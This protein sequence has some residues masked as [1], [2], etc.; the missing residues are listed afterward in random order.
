MQ[1]LALPQCYNDPYA[2]ADYKERPL[3]QKKDDMEEVFI[4]G[5][6]R[7]PLGKLS[8][9]L[10]AIP[11]LALGAAAIRRTLERAGVE[12]NQVDYTPMGNVLQAG[13]DQVPARQAAIGAGTPVTAS[14]MTVNK[15]RASGLTASVLGAGMIRLGDAEVVVAGD[16]ESMVPHL[17]K[18]SRN[19]VRLSSWEMADSMVQG[20]L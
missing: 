2:T 18:G 20:G 11:A 9:A 6:A 17:L 12:P 15:V 7:T 4:V 8:G 10:S 19:G 14:A 1:G 13:V 16:M 5:A 3:W